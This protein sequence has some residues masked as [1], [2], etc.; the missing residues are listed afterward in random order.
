M[1]LN[2]YELTQKE[3]EEND[4]YSSNSNLVFVFSNSN[5]VF[6]YQTR[7]FP[8]QVPKYITKGTPFD[9]SMSIIWKEE[10]T[11]L[12]RTS[13][14]KVLYFVE[15]RISSIK[16]NR[17]CPSV[18]LLGSHVSLELITALSTRFKRFGLWLDPDKRKSAFKQ[19]L[20]LKQ[21]G[22]EIEAIF[23]DRDPKEHSNNE[24]KEI[25]K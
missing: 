16:V 13:T 24:I 8:E 10:S 3:I 6:G 23:S 15:D 2:K 12:G 17:V 5:K 20:N 11:D 25:L 1:W 18:P 21:K 7:G 14:D 22:F 19:C 4:I 9:M